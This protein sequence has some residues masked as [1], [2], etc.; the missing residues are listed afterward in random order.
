MISTPTGRGGS[1]GRG[2]QAGRVNELAEHVVAEGVPRSRTRLC[3]RVLGVW[4]LGS[5]LP[6]LPTQTHPRVSPPAAVAEQYLMPIGSWTSHACGH[7][8]Q[9]RLVWSPVPGPA[10]VDFSSVVGMFL[11]FPSVLRLDSQ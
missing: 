11:G 8:A 6:V 5:S 1:A 10:T 3:H 7:T 9:V 2:W 4:L